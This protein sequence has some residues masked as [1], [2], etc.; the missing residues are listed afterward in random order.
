MSY[1]IS[2]ADI[3]YEKMYTPRELAYATRIHYQQIVLALKKQ[4]A[5][6]GKKIG[7]GWHILGSDFLAWIMR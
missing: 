4:N 6:K 3:S 5:L 2:M 7:R 1:P